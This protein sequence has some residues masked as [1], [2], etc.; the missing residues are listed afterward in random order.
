MSLKFKDEEVPNFQNGVYSL[1]LVLLDKHRHCIEKQRHHS[2]D[3]GPYSQN[4]SFSSSHVLM[5]RWTI[6]K[7]KYRRIDAFRLWSWRRLEST[8]DCKSKQINPKG[9]QP[10]IFFGRT[11]ADTE[12]PILWLTYCKRPWCGKDW[13]QKEKRAAEDEMAEQHGWLNGPEFEQTL[14]DSEGRGMLVCCSSWGHEE[15]DTT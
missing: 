5:W 10:W 2:A 4:Y 9:N 14:G 6:R 7:A 13:R 15:P 8:L 11:D 12:G 3:K 1:F